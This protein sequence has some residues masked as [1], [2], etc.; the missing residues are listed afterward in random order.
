MG[1][2]RDF[3]FAFCVGESLV[4][5]VIFTMIIEYTELSSI[6]VHPDPFFYPSPSPSILH[7]STTIVEETSRKYYARP[8]ER[9]KVWCQTSDSI[10]WIIRPRKGLGYTQPQ[11]TLLRFLVNDVLIVEESKKQTYVR[12]RLL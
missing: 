11:S 7:S 4:R 8:F 10:A 2:D 3:C 9:N 12:S 5:D 1:L 6:Y